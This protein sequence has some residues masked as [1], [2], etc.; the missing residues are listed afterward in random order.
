M[1]DVLCW[2]VEVEVEVDAVFDTADGVI[3]EELEAVARED[4]HVTAVEMGTSRAGTR[5]ASGIAA[6]VV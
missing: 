1:L 6:W 5:G 2:S 3:F 4:R